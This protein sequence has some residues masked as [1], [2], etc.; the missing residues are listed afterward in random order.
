MAQTVEKKAGDAEKKATPEI[1]KKPVIEDSADI[2][3]EAILEAYDTALKDFAE[4]EVI[5]GTVIKVANDKVIV[6]VGFK[7]EGVIS[8]SEFRTED[9]PAELKPGDSVDVLLESIETDGSIVLSRESL[10]GRG[11]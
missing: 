1:T 9:G 7:S 6:D 3:Y 4:G 2:D 5:S 8:L 11:S 10:P